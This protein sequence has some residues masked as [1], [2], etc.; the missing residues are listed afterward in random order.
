M[1]TVLAPLPACLTAQQLART[2]D[3]GLFEL[4]QQALQQHNALLEGLILAEVVRRIKFDL[5]GSVL[6]YNAFAAAF[7]DRAA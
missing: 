2:D 6:V 4:H 3:M 1:E 7:Q 5:L